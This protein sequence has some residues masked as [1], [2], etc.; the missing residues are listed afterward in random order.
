M[1]VLDW[2][3]RSLGVDLDR[4][5]GGVGGSAEG[6]FRPATDEAPVTLRASLGNGHAG[7][8]SVRAGEH[9]AEGR[10]TVS[11]ELG[12]A[13]EMRGRQAVVRATVERGSDRGDAL[14]AVTVEVSQ[15]PDERQTYSVESRFDPAGR[16][17]LT[18]TVR[19]E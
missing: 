10:G 14:A 3:S 18:L 1:S 8:L 16:A 5:V 17:P 2:L 12:P 6:T 19:F 7:T 4:K 11:V 13:R 15:P 9:G